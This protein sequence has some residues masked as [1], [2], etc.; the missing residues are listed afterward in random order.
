MMERKMKSRSKRGI[1][2]FVLAGILAFS[3]T[4]FAKASEDVEQTDQSGN[5]YVKA[6][7]DGT[8]KEVTISDALSGVSGAEELPVSVR[9]S[10]YLDGKEMKPEEMAGKSGEVRIRFD[11]ENHTSETV[12]MDGKTVEVKVPFLVISTL[13][14]P[15]DTF[16]NIQV[17][18]GKVIAS[19][20][21]NIVAGLAFPGLADSLKLADYE[22]TKE[23]SVPDCVEVTADVKDFEL[24]LTASI[25]TPC[26]LSDMD[27]RDLSDVDELTDSMDTL[28]DASSKLTEGVGELASGMAAYQTYLEAY[29]TGI[30]SVN[31]GASALADGLGV[32]NE[33]KGSLEEGAAVIQSSLESLHTVLSQI[34]I[35][36]DFKGASDAAAV[37]QQDAKLLDENLEAL[38]SQISAAEVSLQAVDLSQADAEATVQAKQQAQALV[39]SALADNTELTLEQ[40]EQVLASIDFEAIYITGTTAQAQQELAAIESGL[41]GAAGAIDASLSENGNNIAGLIDHMQAQADILEGYAQGISGLCAS[42]DSL[43]GVL[44]TLTDNVANLKSASQQMTQGMTALSTGIGQAYDGAFALSSGTAQLVTAGS[45]LNYGFGSLFAGTGTL[46]EAMETFDREGIRELSK[47]AGD[48]LQ[49][50]ITRFR[51][52]K[53][54]EIRYNTLCRTEERGIESVKFIIETEAIEMKE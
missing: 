41:A 29:Q 9:V 13:L 34:S 30:S 4:V 19:E 42:V 1:L 14:L 27:M 37:L 17:S 12:D 38:K 32:L 36:S 48:E 45:E 47:L 46:K 20:D 3:P 6:E 28:T 10:Y 15:Q 49:E 18:E 24:E 52:L 53:E 43:N 5:V 51:A 2:A 25:V 50:V 54:A 7:S 8:V 44:G 40:K 23:V 16:S 33:N 11:Y 22:P 26:G 21:Q 35:P 31:A 39:E